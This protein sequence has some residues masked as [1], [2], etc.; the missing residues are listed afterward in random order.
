MSSKVPFVRRKIALISTIVCVVVLTDITLKIWIQRSLDLYE[1]I[2]V[3]SG[4]FNINYIHNFGAAFG[5]MSGTA[6]EVRKVFLFGITAIATFVILKMLKRNS[7]S[8]I[9]ENIALSLILGG[10]LGNALNRLYLGYVVDFLHFH[11]QERH[12]F[13]SFNVADIAICLGV[14]ILLLQQFRTG[15]SISQRHAAR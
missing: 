1:E 5:F 2:P 4:F 9:L 10:A 13:P 15:R 11:W 7:I 12:H 3:I 6:P 14:G 8:Q